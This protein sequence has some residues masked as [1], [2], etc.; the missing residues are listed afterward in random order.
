MMRLVRGAALPDHGL[1]GGMVMARRC[2]SLLVALVLAGLAGS[3][4]ETPNYEKTL[5]S[6][7]VKT[8]TP[9]LLTFLR[10]RTLSNTERA[11]LEKLV[12]QLGADT[13]RERQ[14][15]SKLLVEAGRRAVP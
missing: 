10:N 5:E 15:A 13:F 4:E 3:A 9:S 8:D 11:R 7:G 1:S 12:R 2:L 14:E 6:A